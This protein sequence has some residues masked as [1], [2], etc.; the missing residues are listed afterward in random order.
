MNRLSEASYLLNVE[1]DFYEVDVQK[2]EARQ[3]F[4]ASCERYP[5]NRVHAISAAVVRLYLAQTYGKMGK[6]DDMKSELNIA[7]RLFRDERGNIHPYHDSFIRQK[8]L[9]ILTK[10][11]SKISTTALFSIADFAA[12]HNYI[13]LE[14]MALQGAI[15][16]L[17]NRDLG[18]DPSL[19]LRK[20]LCDDKLKVGVKRLETRLVELGHIRFL[21]EQVGLM[22]R[23]VPILNEPFYDPD[24]WKRFDDSY[25]DFS[26][27]TLV[28]KRH[29]R[30]VMM[31]N[32][33]GDFQSAY[34][35]AQ[36][37]QSV[38]Q[39]CKIF[40][41]SHGKGQQE[42]LTAAGQDIVFPLEDDPLCSQK[43][44]N[45]ETNNVEGDL[46]GMF[47]LPFFQKDGTVSYLT[48]TLTSKKL[49]SNVAPFVELRVWILDALKRKELV[50]SDLSTIFGLDLSTEAEWTS[51]LVSLE[52]TDLIQRLYGSFDLPTSCEQWGIIL[53]TFTTWLLGSRSLPEGKRH[54]ML[55]KLHAARTT[56][57]LE[58]QCARTGRERQDH[59]QLVTEYFRGICLVTNMKPPAA[60]SDLVQSN[61]L[62]WANN[63]SSSL[64]STWIGAPAWSAAME[65]QF[66]QMLELLLILLTENVAPIHKASLNN[67]IG[68]LYQR[69]LEVGGDIPVSLALMHLKNAENYFHHELDQLRTQSGIETIEK[70]LRSLEKSISNHIHPTAL[71]ILVQ[72][73][74]DEPC[75]D[76]IWSWVQAAKCRGLGG[77]GKCYQYEE[78]VG[79]FERKH[80]AHLAA[81][82]KQ[83]V[84]FI[85]FY[86]NCFGGHAGPPFMVALA[87][88]EQPRY[89]PFDLNMEYLH[90]R[91]EEFHNAMGK[92]HELPRSKKTPASILQMFEKLVQPILQIT[93]PSDVLVI[94]PCGVLYGIPLHAI[95]IDGQPLIRR[96]PIVYTTS[97]KVLYTAFLA[98]EF[99]DRSTNDDTFQTVV[100]GEPP[101]E[102]GRQSVSRVSRQL[103][104][105]PFEGEGFTKEV[106]ML[107][108][109]SL[110]LLH[111]HGHATVQGSEPFEQALEFVDAP[112][113][114][115]DIFDLPPTQKSYHGTI[116]GCSSGIIV[117]SESNEPLGLVPALLYS[118]A[119][120]V[121]S[122]LWRIDDE[123]AS[124]FADVFYEEFG[125]GGD[126]IDLARAAQK[127]TLSILDSGRRDIYHWGSFVIT[128][129]WM[130]DGTTKPPRRNSLVE[131]AREF[132]N[133]V[134]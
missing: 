66:S 10:E 1:E 122:A 100:F 58:L 42:A 8:E 73:R 129:W 53:R 72:G 117:R 77:I 30:L 68:N 5:S 120:S 89:F 114:A 90:A 118:G 119:S 123:D 52:P 125:A 43:S 113:T 128:G 9:I 132:D 2:I 18:V 101:T 51:F 85:D 104:T 24:W 39:E 55:I 19:H 44:G 98:R 23:L 38:V 17:M 59:S 63:L 60:I 83:K 65:Q 11:F 12:S 95:Q 74:S 47:Q 79:S 130:I 21:Y 105:E 16:V 75:V 112:L 37:A 28:I 25:P 80:L 108:F 134:L 110:D 96:N 61:L 88:G 62:T 7:K 13:N 35:H 67:S 92:A 109:G 4:I 106:F 26:L 82:S 22:I 86:T 131:V 48:G 103:Q 56:R 81:H 126:P 121:V 115:R 34:K 50:P 6:R 69:K 127:A 33:S 70:Y 97:M 45:N 78:F 107:T 20:P 57:L 40:W 41:D 32:F 29:L 31:S 91:A 76:E 93:E 27:W 36:D 84:V 99:E 124:L 116:L 133:M 111:Y 15:A 71:R 3:S 54:L 87:T 49:G 94:S 102:R 14:C 64:N 46:D